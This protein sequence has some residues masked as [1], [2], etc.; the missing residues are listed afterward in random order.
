MSFIV[1]MVDKQKIKYMG[2]VG[3]IIENFYCNGFFGRD[4]DFSG[5]EIIAEGDEYLVIRKKNGIVQFANFQSWDWNRNED[6]TLS[7]GIS[8]LFCMD[9]KERQDLIDYWCEE[10]E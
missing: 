10:S 3:R 8:N 2:N 1:E 9:K 4:Y 7:H 5:A 6:G